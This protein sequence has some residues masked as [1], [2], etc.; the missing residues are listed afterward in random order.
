MDA[1]TAYFSTR[2][3]TP[4]DAFDGDA[5]PANRMA[6][7][8]CGSN[9]NA[10]LALLFVNTSLFFVLFH[11]LSPDGGGDSRRPPKPFF[12]R[13]T[14]RRLLD[15]ADFRYVIDS[16]VCGGNVTTAAP[17]TPILVHSHASHF[18]YRRAIRRSYPPAVLDRLGLLRHVFMTGLPD[19]PDAQ[20]RLVRESRRH[21]DIVQGSFR[22][23]YRNL[24]YK[25]VMGLSWFAERCG[26][27]AGVVKMD[28][29]IAVNAYALS[30]LAGR[31]RGD[32]LAGCVIRAKP[33]R[34]ARS[35]WYVTRDEYA[36]DAYPP[37]LSG[38]LYAAGAPAV[39]RLLRAVRPGER[40]LWIDD[41]FVTGV[42]ADRAGVR[43]TEDLRP[44]F[45]TDPGPVHCCVR[46]RQRCGFLAAPT[47]DDP[48]LLQPYAERL[49]RCAAANDSCDAHRKS[50]RHHPCLDL[51]KKK[52]A[53]LGPGKPSVEILH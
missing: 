12:D 52:R 20:A 21:G 34:D 29:D 48:T 46:R 5:P 1:C 10:V 42:L 15:L 23:A 30:R 14:R 31:A 16:D 25:H 44:E 28:D 45:E 18:E 4:T 53:P 49:A 26:A 19:G 39:R 8:R 36:A 22:E 50:K 41:L 35:K 27:A 2:K 32:G 38:W 37:F 7:P 6:R 11:A 40:C 43:P 17:H 47:G 9:R 24:T 13:G 3:Y 33:V 51:W